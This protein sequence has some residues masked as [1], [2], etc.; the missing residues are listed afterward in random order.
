MLKNI[1]EFDH[2]LFIFINH[3]PHN[4]LS[5]YFFTFLSGVGVWGIVWLLLLMIFIIKEEIKDKKSF[6]PL[7]FSILVSQLVV[8]I[9]LKNL[10]G[11]LRP[12]FNIPSAI[13]IWDL[14]R[15]YS[16]PSGHATTA[17]AGAFILAR[18]HPKHIKL[19]YLLACLVAF[20]RIYLGKHYPSDVVGGAILGSIIGWLSLK[21]ADFF[22]HKKINRKISSH[23]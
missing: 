21:V 12:Q 17:F 16:F 11:R 6:Y 8:E 22:K 7:I 5:D 9:F 3:L 20:S 18:T 2:S 14:T 10:L 1:I 13:V 15:S 23:K 19:F 4:L